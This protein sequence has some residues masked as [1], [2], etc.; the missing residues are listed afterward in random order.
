MG[1]GGRAGR[2]FSGLIRQGGCCVKWWVRASDAGRL[3]RPDPV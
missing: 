2:L 1:E 3:R